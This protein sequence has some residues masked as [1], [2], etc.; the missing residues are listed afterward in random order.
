M[1]CH[2]CGSPISFLRIRMVKLMKIGYDFKN[3][4]LLK[5]ALTHPS[6]AH[7]KGKDNNQR[8]EFLGDSILS[9]IIADA[10]YNMYPNF[11]EGKLTKL[12]ATLVCEETLASISTDLEIGGAIRFGKSERLSDGIHKAS[13]L[14]DTFEAVLGAIYLDSDIETAREWVLGLFKEKIETAEIKQTLDYKSKLQIYFQ[15]R[16][17]NTEVVKYRIIDRKGPDHSPIF[18]SEALYRDKVIGTGI[19]KNRKY[20]EKNAAQDA[21]ERLGVKSEKV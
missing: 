4:K 21:L 18:T 3:E 17:K 14:A 9:F 2:F 5:T 15:K 7:D 13:I 10:I 19:G 11:D 8:L 12:R 6:Y 20:A 16:D 1:G